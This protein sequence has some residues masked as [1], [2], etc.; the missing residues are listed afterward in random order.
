MKIR[1]KGNTV[2][3]R[4]TKSEVDKL[5]VEG[6]FEEKTQFS[7]ATFRYS[8]KSSDATEISIDFN[9]NKIQVLIP[10]ELLQDWDT[11]DRVGFSNSVITVDGSAVNIL[12]EKD[13]VCLD[14]R[15]EDESDN[16]P[17]PKLQQE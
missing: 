2:R 17:N 12:I 5:C 6:Y 4:L 7:S 16:Y 8:V 1:I 9:E 10:N 14:E 13:F 3:Y 11:N 15:G